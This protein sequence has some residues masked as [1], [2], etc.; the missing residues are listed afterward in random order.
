MAVWIKSK[1]MPLTPATATPARYSVSWVIYFF[2][3]V[4]TVGGPLTLMV[5]PLFFLGLIF[6]PAR[7]WSDV[8]L[9][10]AARLL[11]D[12]QPWIHVQTNFDEISTTSRPGLLVVSNH[13]SYLDAFLILSRVRGV[14]ILAR[15]SLLWCF[16]LAPMLFMT[17][18]VLVPRGDAGAYLRAMET[19]RR[20]LRQGEIVHVFP[21]M[22]RCEPGMKGS[23]N[24]SAAPFLAA[25]QEKATIIP[26]VFSGTDN[27]WPKGIL[28]L[29]SR[30]KTRVTKLEAIIFGQFT[31]AN[32][33][34][35]EVKR[36][37]D[38]ALT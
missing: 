31:S 36:R 9:E 22:T 14:R 18:Q 19:I 13:R 25:I 20:R 3:S 11:M 15:K 6:P 16:P 33:L 24:F 37:I 12:I 34:R 5:A 27:A 32:E 30:S 4:L 21:E 2:F 10:R 8:L 26:L 1:R 23:G 7:S 38:E 28:G 17:K 29:N 35:N